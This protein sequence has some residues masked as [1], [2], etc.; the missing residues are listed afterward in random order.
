M[1]C[2][3]VQPP[4]NDYL[5]LTFWVFAYERFDYGFFVLSF[6]GK[7]LKKAFFII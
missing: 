5:T 1:I 7:S 3:M 4:V 6:T 2:C